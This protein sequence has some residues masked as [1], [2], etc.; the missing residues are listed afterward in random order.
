LTGNE[1]DPCAG[2]AGTPRKAGTDDVADG[3]ITT[4]K[5]YAGAVTA[6]K[7]TV[8]SLQVVNTNTGSLTV[9][10]TLTCSGAITA[11]SLAAGADLTL[12]PA[13]SN[14]AKIIFANVG[15][16]AAYTNTAAGDVLDISSASAGSDGLTFGAQNRWAGV[17]FVVQ[18]SV[19]VRTALL[20]G[21]LFRVDT[22]N[23]TCYVDP[24]PSGTRDL[25]AA[26][27]RWSST[28]TQ[29]L[30]YSA[31]VGINLNDGNNNIKMR[32]G[33]HIIF[34]VDPNDEP[35]D[36]ELT[37]NGDF[38]FYFYESGGTSYINAKYRNSAGVVKTKFLG[39]MTD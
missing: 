35:A 12:T 17:I 14:P 27:A 25:G 11:M 6:D 8:A 22:S 18:D 20:T 34:G 26:A 23:I 37:T 39:G 36:G 29:N 2:V 1:S 9:T 21:N 10:G 19:S 16:I 24:I 38:C 15:E 4:A 5:I 30:L 13:D 3:A 32:A 28:Y 33:D 31:S 7:I